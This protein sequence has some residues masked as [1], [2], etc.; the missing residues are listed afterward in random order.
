[1]DKTILVNGT[2]KKYWDGSASGDISDMPAS[3][4]LAVHRNRLYTA[5]TGN[6]N[7]NISA[8]RKY[9]DFSTAGDAATIVVETRD[10]GGCTGLVQ[11]RDHI[12]FFKATAMLELFG[13]NPNNWQMQVASEQIGCISHR[14]IVEVDGILYFLSNEG[15]RAYGGGS[16]P[17]LI[18]YNV[19]DYIDDMDRTRR[20]AAGTDGRRYYISLPVSNDG[21]VLLVY[22]TLTKTWMAED[23]T[24]IIAFTNLNNILYGLDSEGQIHKMVDTDGEEEISWY[25]VLKPFSFDRVSGKKTFKNVYVT[26]SMPTGSSMKLY[27]T[28]SAEGGTYTE[29]Y[30]YTAGTNIQNVKT[31]IPLTTG[32][33]CDWL[34]LKLSGTGACT[35]HKMEIQARVRPNGW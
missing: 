32:Y 29:L 5:N 22:D 8:L 20:A 24:A 34:K 4:F 35:I 9:D 25:A 17:E 1:M 7:L 10:G 3:H 15:V 28:E 30:T 12:I 14:S 27:G 6:Q 21:N 23:D 33:N 16:D 18:S 31:M 26:F 13:T 11:Y 2:D 19:Q